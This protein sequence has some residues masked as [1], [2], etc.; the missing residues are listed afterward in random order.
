MKGLASAA[1]GVSHSASNAMP[2]LRLIL[3]AGPPIIP[4]LSL[5]FGFG[6]Q[7][8]WLVGGS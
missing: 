4:G 7:G 3:S 6:V 1:Q 8:S 5:G 2:C